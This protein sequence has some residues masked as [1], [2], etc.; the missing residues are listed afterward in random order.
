V[1]AMIQ[2]YM[3]Q[4]FETLNG[5]IELTRCR[6][7]VNYLNHSNNRELKP[8]EIPLLIWYSR[9]VA[10]VDMRYEGNSRYK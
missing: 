4:V 9:S 6:P 8:I 10:R 5:H 2:Q 7:L 3:L 1:T